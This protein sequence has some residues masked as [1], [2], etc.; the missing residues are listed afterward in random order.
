MRWLYFLCGLAS[1]AMIASG[2]V[3]FTVKRR[4]K[5]ASEGRLAAR[6]Y[7]VV[8][9]VNIATVAGLSLACV[10]LLWANR[11]MPAELAGR[12]D[13]ELRVFFGLWLVSLA[14]GLL[15]PHRQA[16]REQLGVAAALCVS[17]PLLSLFSSVHSPWT[18]LLGG[19]GLRAWLELS[20]LAIGV[21]LAACVWHVSRPAEVRAPR[22]TASRAAAL[23]T[24]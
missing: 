9:G 4:R 21:A 14:H 18:A 17:L 8:E 20:S 19:D 11:L 1:C 22:R 6:L 12:V 15:R 23:E 10:G 3:L 7:Q 24:V 5:Y 13:W 16:W 2:L